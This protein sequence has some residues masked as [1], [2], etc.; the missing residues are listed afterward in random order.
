MLEVPDVALVQGC[1]SILQK[2]NSAKPKTQAPSSQQIQQMQARDNLQ[3]QDTASVLPSAALPAAVPSATMPTSIPTST[4]PH[5]NEHAD[6]CDDDKTSD[7][8][9]VRQ[10]NGQ[11]ACIAKQTQ[12]QSVPNSE[13]IEIISQPAHSGPNKNR[14]PAQSMLLEAMLDAE[15][16]FKDNLAVSNDTVQTSDQVDVQP[17]A[18]T[19]PQPTVSKSSRRIDSLLDAMLA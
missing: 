1:R 16:D 19:L 15:S 14:A 13:T 18:Q 4:T 3:E 11:V 9:G 8:S 12:S 17:V 10:N 5:V 6:S 7:S 2:A